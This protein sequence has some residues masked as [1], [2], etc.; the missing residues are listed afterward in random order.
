M[1]SFPPDNSFLGRVLV[2]D[3]IAANVRLLAGILKVADYE[4]LTA[5]SGADALQKVEK[6]APDVVLLD[7]MMPDLDGFEVCRRLRENPRT[8]ALPIVM[9]T[10][11]HETEDRVRALGSRSRRFSNQTRQRNRSC[12]AR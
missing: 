12:G 8:A 6:F 11:L 10:A 4:V 5:K 2:V 3:D 7:V 9:V 1:P